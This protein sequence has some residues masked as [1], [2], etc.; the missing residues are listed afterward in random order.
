MQFIASRAIIILKK[1]NK[2]GKKPSF[3]AH[4]SGQYAGKTSTEPLNFEEYVKFYII[5]Y[6]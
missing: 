6:P 4:V 2:R 1:I 5:F 3:A